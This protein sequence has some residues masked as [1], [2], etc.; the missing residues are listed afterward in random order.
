MG[1]LRK[2][3][4]RYGQI[5]WT[6]GAVMLCLAMSFYFFG[7]R[8][9]IAR[10]ETLEIQRQSKQRDVDETQNKA[11]TL[12]ILVREVQELE[13]RVQ[14]YDRQFPRQPQIGEFIRDMTR[15]SQQLSLKN[16]NYKPAAPRRSEGYYELPIVM[17]FQGD[18]V[19]V[20][21]FLRQVEEMP[22]LTRVKRL[23]LRGR[24]PRAGTV[25]VEMSMNIYFSEG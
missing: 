6:L 13:K 12:P 5:Q 24:D 1:R 15:I 8:P 16:W 25:E 11:R 2:Q 3:I 21:S 9:A 10:L 22:R 4:E 19:N 17:S 7:Y 20:M 18:F 23:A 14:D